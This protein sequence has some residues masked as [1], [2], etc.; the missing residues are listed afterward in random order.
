MQE[1]LAIKPH[2]I[3]DADNC[4]EK[5]YLFLKMALSRC[6]AAREVFLQGLG[7]MCCKTGKESGTTNNEL[8]YY[9]I[10]DGYL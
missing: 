2:N 10:L 6:C 1:L 4:V 3:T 8:S 9:F 5:N 7:M